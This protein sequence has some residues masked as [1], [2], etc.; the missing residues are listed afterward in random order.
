M[1]VIEIDAPNEKSLYI[2][3]LSLPALMT[4]IELIVQMRAVSFA[5]HASLKREKSVKKLLNRGTVRVLHR[6][7]GSPRA[8]VTR[9]WLVHVGLLLGNRRRCCCSRPC[10]RIIRGLFAIYRARNN[11]AGSQGQGLTG[12][13]D[14]VCWFQN[15]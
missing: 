4:S 15:A 2:M 10:H 11:A 14:F 9:P 1:A 5:R 7:H 3:F 12:V 6:R 8:N 13:S